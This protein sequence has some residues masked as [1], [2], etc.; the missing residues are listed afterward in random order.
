MARLH[1]IRTHGEI[2]GMSEQA[3][4]A[5]MTSEGDVWA[6]MGAGAG[7]VQGDVVPRWQA[8]APG[9]PDAADEEELDGVEEDLDEEDL[10][11]D[12]ED[13]DDEDDDLDE[14][15]DDELDD[16][17]DDDDEADEIDFTED[18]YGRIPGED[19]AD[20]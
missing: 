3:V 5:S 2:A 15:E 20:V 4:W 19:D 12:D 18:R 14:F 1:D 16:D 9:E 11:D 7:A 13:D 17:E 10:D 6:S 8:V